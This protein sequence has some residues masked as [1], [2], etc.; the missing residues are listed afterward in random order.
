MTER[1]RPGVYVEEDFFAPPTFE[2]VGIS[3]GGMVG[4]AKKGPIDRARLVSSFQEFDSL[5]GGLWR[6]NYLPLAV[7]AFFDNGGRRL[8][9]SRI[10]GSGAG[11][12][13]KN[14]D[15]FSGSPTIQ[16]D[17][18]N[19]GAWGDSISLRTIKAQTTLAVDLVTAATEAELTSVRG[20][21]VGDQVRITD[22]TTTV[23]VF[24]VSVDTAT[25]KITFQAVTLGATITAVGSSVTTSSRHKA[26]TTLD[27]VL[28][29]GATQVR[30][31]STRN[32]VV[33][34]RLYADDGTNSVEFVVTG[35]N[36]NVVTMAAITLAG[37]LAVGTAV[38]SQEFQIDVF[39]AGVLVDSHEFLSLETTNEEDY[40]ETRLSGDGNE[41]D[42]I[43]VTDL[44]L[45]V[46]QVDLPAP[47]DEVFLAGGA[48]GATPT[49]NDFIGSSADPKSG[50]YLFDD[51]D[52]VNFISTPGVTASA[53]QV[54]GVAYAEGRKDVVY[55]METPE[56]VDTI[57]EAEEYRV[58]TLN[59]DSSYAALYWP[60]LK[61]NDP[62][63]DNAIITVPPSGVVQGIWADVAIQRGVHKAPANERVRNILGLV[64]DGKAID[65]DVAQDILNPIGVNV[66]RPFPGRGVRV[67]GART[68]FG[69]KDGRHYIHVRRTLN[70]I[71]ESIL[72]N[73]L[74]AVFEPIDEELFERISV[75]LTNFLLQTLQ[76]GALTPKDDPEKAFFVKVDEETTTQSDQNA[77]RVNVLV[78]VNIVG[79]AE[80][81]IFKI[82]AFDGGRL[83]EEL[84]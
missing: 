42:Y 58:R 80:Q 44:A 69:V 77:G 39:D 32:I 76:S 17:A 23:D 12:S 3:S 57:E 20:I 24:V 82:T 1:L 2:G 34:T 61:I 36:G 73:S 59:V 6:G 71:E 83:V 4:V 7:R 29:T 72:D 48:D 62:E 30:L 56:T 84:T 52:D 8:Y 50:I 54:N 60:W 27:E 33:G 65:F 49:D 46:G 22:G 38:V 68:L 18:A 53:V 9:V 15:S 10:V 16:V 64:T 45:G 79:T 35:V 55:I 5:Y 31:V 26:S 75:A 41:S 25:K 81:V 28:V 13:T 66:I 51:V 67:F 37:S 19:P 11:E 21:D 47:V 78:G 70:F 14:L 43:F 40:V 63:S 74:F